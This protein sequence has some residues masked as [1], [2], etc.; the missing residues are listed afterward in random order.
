MAVYNRIHRPL[1]VLGRYYRECLRQV[2]GD[3]RD[4]VHSWSRDNETRADGS[5][6]PEG[7]VSHESKARKE[8][9]AREESKGRKALVAFRTTP[10]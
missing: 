10:S 2:V 1:G 8:S 3:L 4:L 5:A 9:K 7:T 6:E